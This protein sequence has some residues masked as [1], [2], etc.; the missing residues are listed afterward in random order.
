MIIPTVSDTRIEFD[1]QTGGWVGIEP[2][3]IA[4]EKNPTLTLQ[5]GELYEIGW[6]EGEGRPAQ[7]RTR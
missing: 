1:A 4:G 5:D 7:Y 3:E 6:E 2:E